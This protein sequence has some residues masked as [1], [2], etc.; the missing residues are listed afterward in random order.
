M[1]REQIAQM[2]PAVKFFGPADAADIAIA[3]R[4]IEC[5]FPDELRL[6]LLESDGVSGEYLLPL[7]WNTH[8]ISTDNRMFRSQSSFRELFMPFD[9]LLF[10][11]DAG[12]GDQFAFAIHGGK[13]RG[14]DVFVWDHETDSRTCIAPS[15]VKYLEWWLSGRISL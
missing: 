4:S 1:W 5:A 13:V 9:H 2:S 7:I 10:F 8:R 11:G 14:S 12:N 3:E 6:L 15:L